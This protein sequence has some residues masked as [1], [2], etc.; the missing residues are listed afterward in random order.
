MHFIADHIFCNM[1]LLVIILSP[2]WV[3][4][5]V[6]S[7]QPGKFVTAMYLLSL[8]LFNI[9]RALRDPRYK[10]GESYMP[11]VYLIVDR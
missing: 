7:K 3:T 2:L 1:I 4:I 11:H 5:L 10:Y 6:L 9:I 8:F